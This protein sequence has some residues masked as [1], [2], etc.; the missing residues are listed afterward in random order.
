MNIKKILVSVLF[1]SFACQNVCADEEA[2]A[3]V[4]IDTSRMVEKAQELFQDPEVSAAAVQLYKSYLHFLE[5][6][7]R[8]VVQQCG[9]QERAFAN[10]ALMHLL[11]VAKDP[12]IRSELSSSSTG[13]KEKIAYL[14]A[15]LQPIAKALEQFG[16]VIIQYTDENSIVKKSENISP[17]AE[18]AQEVF[19][20][21]EVSA[22]AVQI[23]KLYLHF[24]ETILCKVA[25]QCDPQERAFAN[26]AMYL[27][28]IAKDPAIRSELSSSS[29]GS[30]EKAVYLQAKLQPIVKAFEQFGP[31]ILLYVD[32]N[33]TITRSETRVCDNV[34]HESTSQDLDYSN[35]H[36][37]VGLLFLLDR[38]TE[39]LETAHKAVQ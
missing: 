1:L 32:D 13:S 22:A 2:D 31:A 25:Q 14:L 37:R 29:T 23:C 5:T 18:K 15:K 6:T 28:D 11:D 9:P 34:I 30:K 38:V 17:M 39:I 7:L 20:D 4:S 10:M 19:Q 16:S 3:S 36:V 12:V 24:L 33:F 35:Q 27:R 21:P 8:K 26:M